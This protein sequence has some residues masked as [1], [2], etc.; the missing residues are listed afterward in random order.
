MVDDATERFLSMPPGQRTQD[1]E[2]NRL[3]ND[4][5]RASQ[6]SGSAVDFTGRFQEAR[7][8]LQQYAVT[9]PPRRDNETA[10]ETSARLNAETAYAQQQQILSQIAQQEQREQEFA[11]RHIDYAGLPQNQPGYNPYPGG[12]TF[13]DFWGPNAMQ[14]QY[15]HS[16]YNPD[17]TP[18]IIGYGGGGADTPLKPIYGGR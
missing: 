13:A 6:G 9:P 16:N 8:Q 10:A 17:G 18:R 5:W 15:W 1:Y 11:T 14:A 12:V 4:L 3:M 2:G 7:D